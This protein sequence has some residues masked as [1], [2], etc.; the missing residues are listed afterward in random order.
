LRLVKSSELV[1][2]PLFANVREFTLEHARFLRVIQL[3]ANSD[4]R[5]A[6]LAMDTGFQG[7]PEE[8]VFLAPIHEQRAHIH[9]QLGDRRKAIESYRRFVRL[10]GDAD[11]A[12]QARVEAARAAIRRLEQSGDQSGSGSSGGRQAAHVRSDPDQRPLPRT[13]PR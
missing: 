13:A 1:S 4:F 9:E 7:S 2:V 6:L 12:L 3:V 11:P 5:S 10:W 8:F